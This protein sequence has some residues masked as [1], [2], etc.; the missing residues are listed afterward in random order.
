MSF[1]VLI[2]TKYIACHSRFIRDIL[3][4]YTFFMDTG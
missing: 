3:H 2:L 1:L 4:D